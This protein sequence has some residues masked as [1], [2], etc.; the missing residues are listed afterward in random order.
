MEFRYSVRFKRCPATRPGLGLAAA[1]AS[2]AFSTEDVSAV[3]VASSGRGRPGGG[4]SLER[5]F[6]RTFSQSSAPAPGCSTS[7]LSSRSPA[8]FEFWLWQVTQYLSRTAREDGVW[9][10]AVR[11]PASR[12]QAY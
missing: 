11:A 12:M 6:R 10:R 4:I 7:A 1:A 3:Y 5:S 2:S 9:A 8:V